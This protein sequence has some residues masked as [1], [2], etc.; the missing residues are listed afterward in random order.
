MSID[1][2]NIDQAIIDRIASDPS[3]RSA[4]LNDP[5]AALAGLSGMQIPE[6]V[7]IT[8]HEESP[9]DIHLV[10]PTEMNLSDEDLDLVAGGLWSGFYCSSQAPCSP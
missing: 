4:L 9:A 5:H 8:I 2:S 1:R 10:I 3:F 6:S 7:N